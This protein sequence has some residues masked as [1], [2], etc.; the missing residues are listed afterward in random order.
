MFSMLLLVSQLQAAV[1]STISAIELLSLPEANRIEIAKKQSAELY[2]QLIEMAFNDERSLQTR[3]NS[4][5]L[6]AQIGKS[7]S[8][9]DIERALSNKNWF[10][11]NAALVA[12]Q[13]IHSD[14]TQKV[15]L[16]LLS[17]KALVVRSA[18]VTAI[19]NHADL[20]TR[21]TLWG[22]LHAGYNFRKG[23]SLWIRR[24]IVEKLAQSPEKKEYAAFAAV[25]KDA[26]KDLHVSAIEAL[27]K[28]TKKHFGNKKSSLADKE[29]LWISYVEKNPI[30]R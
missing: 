12:L 27:E 29:K 1:P 28:I 15:A 18:A 19:D 16:Q 26:D 9:A 30:F 2:P 4:L 8:D 22:E 24:E 3:W 14:K 5:I 20:S 17:D 25:I 6:A 23:Q 13:A 11:R 7:S 21:A 10:M